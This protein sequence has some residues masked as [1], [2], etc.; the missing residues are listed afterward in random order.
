MSENTRLREVLLGRKMDVG[1]NKRTSVSIGQ[2]GETKRQYLQAVGPE[3]QRQ[4]KADDRRKW[5]RA[6]YSQYACR[7][8]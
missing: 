4:R 7:L 6:N 3:E 5:R 2:R 1:W 8:Q